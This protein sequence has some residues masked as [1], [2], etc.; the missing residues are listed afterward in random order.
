M[1]H[2]HAHAE[3]QGTRIFTPHCCVR[4]GHL[5]LRKGRDSGRG[6]LRPSL[7]PRTGGSCP[8]VCLL[9]VGREF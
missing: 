8:P 9:G 4:R 7:L 5:I 3:H 6:R 2:A 1:A